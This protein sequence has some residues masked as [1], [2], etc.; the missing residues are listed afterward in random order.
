MKRQMKRARQ[1]GNPNLALIPYKSIINKELIH[2]VSTNK[3]LCKTSHRKTPVKTI[4]PWK[5]HRNNSV[6]GYEMSIAEDQ[7]CHQYLKPN[8][9][10]MWLDANKLNS[11]LFDVLERL[12]PLHPVVSY[13]GQTSLWLATPP[14]GSGNTVGIII[15]R[16]KSNR[17]RIIGTNFMSSPGRSI[18]TPNECVFEAFDAHDG[19][20]LAIYRLIEN[21]ISARMT[22]EEVEISKII[23]HE[24]Y[25]YRT[26]PIYILVI[27]GDKSYFGI[28]TAVVSGDHPSDMTYEFAGEIL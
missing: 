14:S 18:N 22:S 13:F 19:N 20:A 10:F 2:M 5:T 4:S 26:M 7:S 12:C 21:E 16:D 17:L 11:V 24:A 1:G 23:E 27:D 9:L 8:P 25:K 15:G 6:F 28:D 3:K